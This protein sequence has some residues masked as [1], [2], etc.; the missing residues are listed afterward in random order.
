[1]GLGPKRLDCVHHLFGLV[2]ESLAQCSCPIQ[3]RIHLG[4]HLGEFGDL[5]HVVIPR[6]VVQ[7]GNVV[8]V[9]YKSRSLNNLQWIS[10]RWQ[11]D[12]NQ[13]IRVQGDGLDELLKLLGAFLGWS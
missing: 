12:C 4:D 3:V 1:L 5:L 13:R 7:L 8:R 10:R 9:L 11:N 2:N 6:L